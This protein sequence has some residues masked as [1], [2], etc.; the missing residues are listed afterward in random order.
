[1]LYANKALRIIDELARGEEDAENCFRSW[2]TDT[3]FRL[4]RNGFTIFS[5]PFICE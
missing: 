2:Q 1:M 5:D 3:M 4:T